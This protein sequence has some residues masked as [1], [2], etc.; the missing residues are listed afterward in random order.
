MSEP[1]FIEK[2]FLKPPL[3]DFTLEEYTE[4][5][6]LYGYLM[7]IMDICDIFMLKRIT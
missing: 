5:V 2:E 4:K 3:S 7:V 1:S 6:I